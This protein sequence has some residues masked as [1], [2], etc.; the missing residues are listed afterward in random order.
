MIDSIPTEPERTPRERPISGRTRSN[1]TTGTILKKTDAL[2]WTALFVVSVV[3]RGPSVQAEIFYNQDGIQLQGSIRTLA[4][5]AYTCNVLEE[6]HSDEEYEKVKAYQG[7]PLHIW[8]VDYS[9]Y[10]GSGKTLSYLRAQLDVESNWPPCDNWDSSPDLDFHEFAEWTGGSNILQMPYG[11]RLNQAEQRTKYL[12]VFHAEQPRFT[13]WDIQYTFDDGTPRGSRSGRKPPPPADPRRD[14][15]PVVSKQDR[16][17]GKP[18][19]SECWM[20]L[21]NSPGCYVWNPNLQP[22]ETATWTGECAGGVAQGMGTLQWVWDAGKETSESTGSLVEGK[23]HG[24][25]VE[26]SA[27][28]NVGEGPFVEGKL[29]SD[30]WVV[31]DRSG[32]ILPDGKVEESRK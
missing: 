15:V 7:Q 5:N 17:D 11:M 2:L 12:L 24:Q 6:K 10:N 8:Q 25:W 26:R 23:R 31:R 22:D 32:K 9:V 14:P 16:C 21:A 27:D 28:G 4:Y 30:R 1:T 20:E 29:I 3:S 18:K 13:A 19:G